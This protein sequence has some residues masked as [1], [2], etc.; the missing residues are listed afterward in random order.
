[1]KRSD[2]KQHIIDYVA[3]NGHISMEMPVNLF[4]YNDALADTDNKEITAC[5][6]ELVSEGKLVPEV[7]TS[8]FIHLREA[9]KLEATTKDK[10]ATP[11]QSIM[12]FFKADR[13][14]SRTI[15]E[16]NFDS[17]LIFMVKRSEHSEEA[18]AAELIRQRKAHI[19]IYQQ[20]KG[21]TV[22]HG[23]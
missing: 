10:P 2:I 21:L 9:D 11:E 23:E 4:T 22:V 7:G 15:G 13:F 18:T 14:V 3:H 1:M 19:M 20:P 12:H 8:E 6:F 5:L 16:N 17:F